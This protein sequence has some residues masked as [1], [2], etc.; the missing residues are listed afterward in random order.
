MNPKT[1]LDKHNIRKIRIIFP[2]HNGKM[3]GEIVTKKHFL[4]HYKE[5]FQFSEEVLSV[6]ILGQLYSIPGSS[7]I[8][9]NVYCVPDVR[10]LTVTPWMNHTAQV[11]TDTFNRDKTPFERDCRFVM[12][13]ICTLF[14]KKKIIPKVGVELEFYLLKNGERATKGPEAEKMENL[15]QIEEYI[16]L[17]FDY[18]KKMNI[19]INN[20]HQENDGGHFEIITSPEHALKAADDLF[21]LK[22]LL[23]EAARAL[24][25]KT[26]FMARY[27]RDHKTCG[28]HTHLS[29]YQNNKNLFLNKGKE[30]SLLGYSIGGILKHLGGASAF[31]LPNI[32]SY[33]RLD[34]TQW[35]PINHS[36]GRDNRFVAFRISHKNNYNKRV[37]NRVAGIDV[38]P[39]LS[40]AVFLGSAYLGI[41]NRLDPPPISEKNPYTNTKL[42]PISKSL[43]KSL[44]HLHNDHE[45]VSMLGSQ[46]VDLFTT[47]KIAEAEDFQKTVTEWEREKY[48]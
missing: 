36:Y 18:A 37:E 6:G 2:D 12:R 3:R 29:L 38:N 23:S 46:M 28:C 34:K 31:Y 9:H 16:D 21:Y 39:Y 41:K 22:E 1:F 15:S 42:K 8:E 26:V 14:E 33:K 4:E 20:L 5:G 35:T 17:V 10:T 30:S 44:Q 40:H 48:S 47:H 11:I 19:E 32:N 7:G 43:G 13:K 27:S 25:Y 45:L 24:G